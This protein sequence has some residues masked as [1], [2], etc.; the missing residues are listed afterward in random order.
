MEGR[1]K[2]RHS[3]FSSSEVFF[4]TNVKPSFLRILSPH[5]QKLHLS[6]IPASGSNT[7]PS[8][9]ERAGPGNHRVPFAHFSSAVVAVVTTSTQRTSKIFEKYVS[10]RNTT[11]QKI[12]NNVWLRLQLVSIKSSSAYFKP[13]RNQKIQS[14]IEQYELQSS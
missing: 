10:V 9:R 8:T 6:S 11:L 2:R 1:E 12:F 5:W 4:V 3:S 14:I 7:S 13:L